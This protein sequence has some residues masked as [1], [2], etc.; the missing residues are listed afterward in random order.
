MARSRVIAVAA[1]GL[2]V[3]GLSVGGCSIGSHTEGQKITSALVSADGR[4]I[5]VPAFGGG[6]T[7]G[8]DLMAT[9]TPNDV[10]LHLTEHLS[11][12]ACTAVREYGQASTSLPSPLGA[13]RLIDEQTGHAIAY[14]PSQDLAQPGW[15]PAGA[16]RPRDTAM[17]GWTRTYTFATSPRLAPLTIT[18]NPKHFA[19]PGQFTQRTATAVRIHGHPARLVS[20]RATPIS[21]G[22][23]YVGWVANGY[24]II[25]SSM[26][27]RA[28]Q[29]PLPAH[30][31]MRIARAL[32]IP[33]HAP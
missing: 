9:E 1:L 17:N 25:V 33:T 27:L 13:R 10:R 6:C 15:L 11:G 14:I 7:T 2:S 3:L 31:I 5:T 29:R 8:F 20:G 23:T 4:T 28:A 32:R 24:S 22:E 30:V 18:E 26:P 12:G 16:S 19:N 21:V